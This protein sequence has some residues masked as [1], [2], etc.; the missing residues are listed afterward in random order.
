MDCTAAVSYLFARPI[1]GAAMLKDQLDWM[2]KSPPPPSDAWSTIAWWESRRI[3][4]NLL[5]LGY[6]IPCFIVY[7][8]GLSTSGHLQ[9]GE[10]A[11]E[12]LV[13]LAAPIAINV[14]YT[15]GWLVEAPVRLVIPNLPPR[16]GPTLL[17]LGMGLGL[18]WI[19]IPAIFWGGYRILQLVQVVQ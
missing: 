16:V 12:P 6:A 2:F 14:L 3:P 19:S 9:P 15:L 1:E 4:F 10:D 5:I 18:F 17:K 13:L 11:E 7:V 8:W